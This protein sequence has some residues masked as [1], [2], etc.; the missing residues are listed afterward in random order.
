MKKRK[1]KPVLAWGGFSCGKLDYLHL[2][3]GFGGWEMMR[4]AKLPAIFMSK[5]RAMMEYQD[6]RKVEIR[7]VK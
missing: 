3:T 2:D 6:V 1:A 4:P 5:V 7:E